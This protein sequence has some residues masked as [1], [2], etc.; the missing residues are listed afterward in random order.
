MCRFLG[1]GNREI[2]EVDGALSP[3]KEPLRLL[4]A[5][6][7]DDSTVAF[8]RHKRA[9]DAVDDTLPD[10]GRVAKKILQHIAKRWR[11]LK[12][13]MPIRGVDGQIASECP[14]AHRLLVQINGDL[15]VYADRVELVTRKALRP[16]FQIDRVGI[17]SRCSEQRRDDD[18][19][20]QLHSYLV[21]VWRF[22][23]SV[24]RRIDG[25]AIPL[26]DCFA[27]CCGPNLCPAARVTTTVP[28]ATEP[29]RK[30]CLFS[31][32]MNENRNLF[33]DAEMLM[34]AS[35]SSP[36]LERNPFAKL[37]KAFVAH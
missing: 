3:S 20:F 33:P 17:C 34:H 16:A 25:L 21:A 1:A 36:T 32:A 24:E 8:M 26:G 5:V 35:I 7:A 31:P 12:E 37:R 30:A 10:G 27:L 2:S 9:I 19:C 4:L 6:P 15:F 14:R 22:G 29:P 18:G 11:R 23:S 13:Q 28:A